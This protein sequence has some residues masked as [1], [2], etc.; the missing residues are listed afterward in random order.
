MADLPNNSQPVLKR[1]KFNEALHPRA[2][3][4]FASKKGGGGAAVSGKKP[5]PKP[6]LGKQGKR[7]A[8][9]LS[10]RLGERLKQ[11]Q[12]EHGL[13]PTGRPDGDTILAL[14][15]ATSRAAGGQTPQGWGKRPSPA[16][17][18]PAKWNALP[19]EQRKKLAAA[20]QAAGGKLPK[21]RKIGKDGKIV[22]VGQGSAAA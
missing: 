16:K 13:K 19:P 2:A 9:R 21:G 18:P 11:F 7:E 12:K 22:A 5:A 20:F 8:G 6:P 10:Q 4:R 3:G 14:R 1:A 15:A 17:Y